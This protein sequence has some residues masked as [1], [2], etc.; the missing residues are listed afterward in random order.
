MGMFLK[1]DENITK[2]D[3]LL[4]V[5]Q[6]FICVILLILTFFFERLYSEIFLKV[7]AS[8]ILLM[9]GTENFQKIKVVAYIC[10]AAA[11]VLLTSIIFNLS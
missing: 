10:Y 7:F 9:I 5:F 2:K 4:S 11:A 1:N 3:K 6:L 8:L